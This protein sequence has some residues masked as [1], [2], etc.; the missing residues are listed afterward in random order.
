MNTQSFPHSRL[1][2]FENESNVLAEM[3]E[4]T[5]YAVSMDETRY[6]LNGVFLEA[7]NEAHK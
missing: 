6:H 3:I 4:K 5:I 7:K 2:S 1:A